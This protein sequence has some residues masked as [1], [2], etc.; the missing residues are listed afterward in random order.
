MIALIKLTVGHINR[1]GVDFFLD[2]LNHLNLTKT[3]YI[4]NQ[5][6]TKNHENSPRYLFAIVG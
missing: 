1:S 4:S 2:L 6:C 5:T 3:R